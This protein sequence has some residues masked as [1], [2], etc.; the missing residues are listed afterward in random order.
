MWHQATGAT[1]PIRARSFTGRSADGWQVKPLGAPMLLCSMSLGPFE[2]LFSL[3][4]PT[5]PTGD[6]DETEL[7]RS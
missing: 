7:V 5:R 2:S 3:V 4:E 1:R 6:D